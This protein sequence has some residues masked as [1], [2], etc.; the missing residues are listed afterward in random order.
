[1]WFKVGGRIINMDQVAKI[2]IDNNKISF[3][4]SDQQLLVINK[5]NE[6]FEALK[7]YLEK[8]FESYVI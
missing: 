8:K 3:Y 6:R 2:L 5:S 7:D 4:S 1:M